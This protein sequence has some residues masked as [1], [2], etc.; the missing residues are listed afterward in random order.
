MSRKEIFMEYIRLGRTNLTVSKIGFGGAPAGIKNYLA[1][2]DPSKNEDTKP[3]IEAIHKAVE[4]G[5][6]FFDTAPAYGNGQGEMVFG[7]A[8]QG[9]ESEKIYVATKI[10]MNDKDNIRGSVEGSLE[11]LKRDSIDLIQIHGEHI[12]DEDADF[13][14]R[15]GGM[16]DAMYQLKEEGLVKFIGFSSEDQD[17]PMHRM[18]QSNRFDVLQT[19]Y[20]FI[21]QHPCDPVRKSGSLYEAK[22]LDMGT[23]TMRSATS[24]IF[25]KWIQQVNPD[26]TFDYTG[27]L[28]QFVLS[29][30]LVDVVLIGMRSPQE[31]KLNIELLN[32][33]A[34]RIDL[35]D[36]H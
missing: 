25:Q 12:L 34:G 1:L 4:Y 13:I 36:L 30:P 28:I 27:A 16:L 14:L 17:P 19:C 29:N 23:I 24:M 2:H 10:G 6:N 18:I 11:R 7:E 32:D 33:K 3:I 9:I 26:N 31:L 22:K 5:I 8:L 21:F 15:D 35:N 20:N